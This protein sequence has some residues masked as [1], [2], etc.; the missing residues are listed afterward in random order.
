MTVMVAPGT[1]AKLLS[2]TV[3][4]IVPLGWAKRQETES[5]K[6]K[7]NPQFLKSISGSF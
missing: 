1:S 5:N 7:G 4:T 3:P 2:R 6:S